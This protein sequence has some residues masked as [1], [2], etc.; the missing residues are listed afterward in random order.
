METVSRAF[1]REGANL[2]RQISAASDAISIRDLAMCACLIAVGYGILIYT[3]F[4][5]L[6]CIF[7]YFVVAKV[8]TT[9]LLSGHEAVH[10][11]LFQNRKWNDLIGSYV[12]FAPMGVGFYRARASHLDHHGHLLTEQDEKLDQ[13]I[14]KPTRVKYL[15]HL[16]WP[17]F[18]SYMYRGVLRLLGWIPS[19]RAKPTYQIT[20]SQRRADRISVAVSSLVLL[21]V[22]TAIDWRLYPF[23][24]IGP[25]MTVT[26]F[27]HNAKGFLDHVPLS[28]ERFGQYLY[29]YRV[30]WL[31]RLFV[32]VQQARHAEHHLY[33]QV[34][35]HRL[36]QIE[37]VVRKMPGVRYRP[38]YL[39]FLFA[40]Y[41]DLGKT[42]SQTRQV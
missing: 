32:S 9:L 12:C 25:L 23:F 3:G 14:E 24:W 41:V 16:I 38:G 19:R 34:P 40:Y 4:H 28:D 18:G 29:S 39:L 1:S 42:K 2:A 17:L 33:P 10:N 6:S 26:A 5:W 13:Q 7:A 35:Y 22:L 36:D 11:S 30:S 31:D 20:Q 27:F 21:I 37:P 8:Q 15:V